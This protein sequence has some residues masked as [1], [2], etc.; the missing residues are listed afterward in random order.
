MNEVDGSYCEKKLLQRPGTACPLYWLGIANTELGNH[1]KA[2][3]LFSVA[4]E[5]FQRVH[6]DTDHADIAAIF[7]WLGRVNNRSRIPL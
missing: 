7:D 5:M 2:P 4:L 3:E 6:K 1:E